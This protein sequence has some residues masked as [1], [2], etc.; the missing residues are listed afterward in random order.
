MS[1]IQ[2]AALAFA[3]I[4]ASAA[5][6]ALLRPRL[7][8]HHV[9]GDSK[10]VIKLSIALVATMSALVLALLFASTRTTFERT[11]GLVSRLTAE[12]TELDRVLKHYGPEADPVRAALRA[13]IQPMIDSIWREEAVARGVKLDEGKAPEEQVLYMLQ[14]LQPAN[15][16]QRALHVRAIQISADLQQTQIALFAQPADS[17]SN[18]FLIVLIVW[19]MFIF[20]V[21]SMSAPAN[22]TMFVVIATCILSASAAFYLILELGIPFGGLMQLSNE[23]LRNA[24][25]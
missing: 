20:G 4:I 9:S 24:L 18:T 22:P 3:C 23:P 14:D 8:E 17:I 12:I 11:S 15:A 25:K 16:K 2:F 7:P 13:E 1:P 10:D 21:F 19:L 5:A 6:G